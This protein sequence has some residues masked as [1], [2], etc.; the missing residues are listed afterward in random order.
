MKARLVF[1]LHCVLSEGGSITKLLQRYGPFDE[2]IVISYSKQVLQGVAYLHQNQVI[3]RDIKGQ[4]SLSLAKGYEGFEEGGLYQ[5][6]QLVA[7]IA[8]VSIMKLAY[9]V[10]ENLIPPSLLYFPLSCHIPLKLMGLQGNLEVL[11]FTSV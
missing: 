4:P 11:V 8:S 5:K 2:R 10:K 7:G 9:D 3:H 6:K 1:F